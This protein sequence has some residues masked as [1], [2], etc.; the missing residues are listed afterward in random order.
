MDPNGR[1]AG[2]T[3]WVTGGSGY[4]GK[5]LIKKLVELDCKIVSIDLLNRAEDLH[6][7]VIFKHADL[8]DI[9]SLT[10][11]AKQS[12]PSFVY[13]LAA[14]LN[15]SRELSNI[16][17][18]METNFMGTVNLLNSLSDISYH[19]FIYIGTSEVYGGGK[20]E[21]PFKESDDFVPA[22]PYSLSKYCG[23]MAVRT[24]S[25]ILNKNYTILRVFNFLGQ[26]MPLNF[27]P[28]Q[29]K[30]KLYL[31]KDFDMTHGEQIRDFL[32]IDDVI[33]AMLVVN[34]SSENRQIFNV[35]SGQGISLQEMAEKAK[36]IMQSKSTINYGAIPYRMNEVWEMV[37]DNSRIKSICGWQQEKPIWDY[38][39]E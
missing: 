12:S 25:D 20:I 32:H 33:K 36:E 1:L 11:L 31:N 38:F 6:P 22:S 30:E 16:G 13:H 39:K 21:P 10:E 3:V 24:V 2:A 28:S 4:L 5:F 34:E 37:G 14:D 18:V 23:E 26:N 17:P 35:C 15:R 19:N 7:N 9:S 27:F 29:L 8:S